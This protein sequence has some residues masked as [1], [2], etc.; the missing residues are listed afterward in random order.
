MTLRNALAV[1][2]FFVAP[3]LFNPCIAAVA[4]TVAAEGNITALR[5]A[6][7][8]KHEV[9]AD[10]FL[11]AHPTWDGRGVVIGIF[12]TGVDPA[13]AGLTVTSTGERKIVDIID[14]SGSGDVDTSTK[15]KPDA[16][17][18]L[19]ALSGRKLT[20]PPGI[21]NPSGEFRLG[22][23][24]A[25]ELFYGQVLKRVTDERAAARSAAASLRNAA[26]D[27][28]EAAGPLKAA[29]A[30]APDE[31]GRADRDLIAR[32]LALTALDDS[33]DLEATLVYDC[34]V[35]N[36]GTGWRVVVDTNQDGDLGDELTLRPFGIAGEFG[37]FGSV[38]QANFG[39]QVYEGGDLLSIVTVSG[40]HGT[41]VASIAAGNS[42]D[43][44]ARNGIAPGARILSIKIGDIRAGGSSYGTSELRA[45][46]IAAQHRVDIVNASWG[47]RSTLQDGKNQNSRLYDV[48]VERFDILAVV[49]AGN[50][51]PA[52]GTA[53]SA[54]AEASRV[55]GV[56]AYMSREMGTVL[57]NTL[58][59]TAD[60]AQ[61]FS[62]R[63]P[64]KDGDFGVDI[65]APGAAYAS[66]SPESQKRAD[67]FNGTSMASPSAA[68][69]AALVL[70]AARQNKLAAGPALLRSALILGAQP[71][72]D[73][74]VLTRGSGLVNTPGAWKK[75]NELQSVPAFRVFY[76]IEVDQGTFTS[77]GRGL[78]LRESVDETRMRVNVKITPAWAES[79][80]QKARFSF[81]S[82]L[83]LKPSVP[84][85]STPQYVHMTNGPRSVSM[86]VNVPPVAKGAI[87]S[88]HVA[89]VDAVVANQRSLG[90]VFSIPVTLI[91]PAPQSAF[92]K[93]RLDTVVE[94]KPSVTKRHFVQAPANASV[95]R[96]TVKHVAKDSLVRRFSVQA[97]AYAAQTHVASMETIRNLNLATDA[98][99]TF[100]LKLRPG[101]VAEIAYTLHF[102]A[103]GDA[104]LQTRLEWIG[105]GV[106][107]TVITVPAN[108]GW[109][110]VALNPLADRDV[111]VEA[112]IDRA[113]HV[114]LPESTSDLKLDERAELPASP[115]TPGP[116]RVHLLRQRFALDFKEG[117]T[118]HVLEAQDYDL[119]DA[120]GGGRITLTHESGEVLFD[121]PGRNMVT[122][123][124]PVKFLKGKTTAIVEYT[125]TEIDLLKTVAATPL[126]LS[127][128][129]KV[130]SPLPIRASLRERLFG[131]DVTELK[132]KRGREEILFLQDKA[133]DELV[134]QEPK[135]AHFMGE[136]TVRDS[137]N[138]VLDR[139]PIVYIAGASPA[140]V[141][142]ADPKAKP[143]KDERTDV[144]K[145]SDS[146]FDARL[147]FVREQRGTT[148]QAIAFRRAEVLV[149]LRTEKSGDAAIVFEQAL[150]AAIA[151]GLAGDSWPKAKTATG[152][153]SADSRPGGTAAPTVAPAPAVSNPER[154]V[155]ALLDEA[156]R[157]AGPDA[158]AQYFGAPPAVVSGDLAA[159]PAQEREKKRQT[160][161]RETLA[162]IE[163]L[164]AD[165]LRGAGQSDAAWKAF[166]EIKRWEPEPSNK[167]SLAIEM[168]LLEQSGLFGLTLDALNNRLKDEPANKALLAQRAALYDKLG[169][170]N[171]AE[172]ERLRLARFE[173]QKKLVDKL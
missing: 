56:G 31:R 144:E 116:L 2:A 106:G 27:R 129:L 92:S 32:D 138:R 22:L 86:L 124:P 151:A 18:K 51:G 149:A 111:K 108:A 85:I 14:A 16:S 139:Q 20:L 87:G 132:L 17:G 15:R 161:L 7:I 123:R 75:L 90:P 152:D 140:K 44:P 159:R 38:A 33:K 171:A 60:A 145:L 114:F 142:N 12:D 131:K 62:S 26:R 153:A 42:P 168:T 80:P 143:V 146:L 49:S 172:H 91:Q 84:W 150:D 9:A 119:D 81:E 156:R 136:L 54:G 95:L 64:T 61:Q 113:I 77:K 148:D 115:L 166:A 29:R 97:V 134:K 133:I 121:S 50:D 59:D 39:V 1:S 36:D 78:L 79:T 110:T 109:A 99:Q 8:P 41:H 112:K 107:D 98:E 118:A 66:L 10:I 170:I 93:N 46:A 128:A 13:A 82:D 5:S 73:E 117:L 76:D 70:S 67:M 23:K 103:V 147:A 163:R 89:Q 158:V 104:S 71:I 141:I 127:E 6:L 173:Q 83:L 164:R 21:V 25:S 35:W 154:A 24:A 137:E 68:G 125:A 120:V 11:K 74:S 45:T 43:E 57:Y 63:G 130:P 28:S 102:G 155:L 72:A 65:M 157:L 126:R 52:Y 58:K 94:L 100:D 105:T 3:A 160:G 48:M 96:I 55:L 101:V 135:P 37:F 122:G 47:G 40:S 167:Q 88:V 30:K 4:A 69:V 165:V 53:G 169:W 162:K 34:V 19:L